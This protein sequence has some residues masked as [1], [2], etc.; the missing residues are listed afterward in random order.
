MIGSLIPIGKI[1]KP[2]GIDGGLKIVLK[3]SFDG[4]NLMEQFIFVHLEGLP[5]P[6]WVTHFDSNGFDQFFLE[7]ITTKEAAKPFAG[8]EFF[9]E[10]KILTANTGLS[11]N[12]YTWKGYLMVDLSSDHRGII[13]KLEEYPQQ[14]MA[15]VQTNE[16]EVLVPIHEDFLIGV[17]DLSKTITVKLP[18]GLWE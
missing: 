7:Y 13:I 1:V 10:K 8:K 17:D 9:V 18:N 5:V 2:H 14:L 12:P 4:F 16:H 3:D 15:T 6:F 11:S